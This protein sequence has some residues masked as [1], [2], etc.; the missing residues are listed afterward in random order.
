LKDARAAGA[1]I[2]VW[3][4]TMPS[5]PEPGTIGE[6]IRQWA[7]R[8]PDAP[9]FIAEDRLPLTYGA[10]AELMARFGRT[11][12]DSG[13]GRGDRIGI[14]HSGGAEMASTL[15]SV[16][17][18]ATAVPL[19]ST[20][21][22][23][24]F[25]IHLHD[26]KVTGLIV[27]AGMDTPA[28]AAAEQQGIP[29]LDVEPVDD[30]VAGNIVL[31]PGPEQQARLP[32]AA[33]PDDFVF[34]MATSGT[35]SQ[36]KIVPLRHRHNMRR[37]TASVDFLELREDDRCLILQPL[38]Y[39]GG[40]FNLCA[41]LFSGSSVI[42]L[43]CFD[44]ATFFRYLETLGP[45]WYAGSYTFQYSIH[46]Q[47][48]NFEEAIR[49]S[50]LRFIRTTSGFLDSQ[51]ADGIEQLFGVPVIEAY[52]TTESG[53]I[54][55]NPRPP[56]R[57]KRGTVGLPLLQEVEIMSA[58]GRFLPPTERGEVVV[59]GDQV[60]DGYEN[61]PAA[62]EAAFIDGWYR[63]GDEGFFDEDGYLTLT[64]RI[65]ENINRGGEKITPGEVDDALLRHPDVRE[66][67]TFPIP[68]ATLGEEV[69][70]AVVLEK[71]AAVTDQD[72]NRFLRRRL[73][74]FKVPRRIL[75][76]ASIPKSANGKIQRGQL[77]KAFNLDGVG[78][79]ASV[80]ASEN[81]RQSSPL[82]ARLQELW[83]DSLGLERV[84]LHDNF[85]L[86]GGDSLQAVELF[87]RIEEVLGHR[88]PR[89]S[90]FE[91][92]TVAEM[93][94]GI[95]E[96]APPRCVLPI[97]PK[98]TRPPFFCVHDGNGHVLNFWDLARHLGEEQPFYGIQYVDLDRDQLP[99]TEI[100][101]MAA[102]Y[103][104]EMRKVQPVGPYYIGGYSFGG[105][106]AYVMAQQLRAA[107]QEVALLAL[108]DTFSH[109][110]QRHFSIP[111]R[112]ARHCQRIVKMPLADVPAFAALIIR[113]LAVK[114]YMPLRVKLFSTT[115]RYF[116]S[117][118]RPTPR[119]LSHPNPIAIDV[120]NQDYRAQP[121]D[122]SAVLFKAELY[123][124]SHPDLHDGWHKL[125]KGG[126]E[127]RPVPGLHTSIMKEPHVRTLAAELAECLEERHG[128]P[129]TTAQP[130]P[131]A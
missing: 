16:A 24:E 50:R 112:L 111:Y 106:A 6:T 86:L 82:E 21:T 46:A 64:G 105:R 25:A 101:A 49:R 40:L 61:N 95:E 52:A 84:G 56:G 73:A 89:S 57:N 100:D 51:I 103:I 30:S 31:R 66:A 77:S 1:E 2:T 26:R 12:N 70:A 27:E 65:K 53:R 80:R 107:G 98:G 7:E 41:P 4:K 124:M 115:C 102:H 81:D 68:H 14:V 13:Y 22:V 127:I 59:R 62:N 78:A 122:G 117:R 83:A 69:A 67:T 109:V 35:T 34:V 48:S 43:T 88:L 10:L 90:L 104:R 45:T 116:K 28:R 91:A 118:N 114:A 36:S 97:Q 33:A 39:A 18:Y 75:F 58:E 29:V 37:T 99:F 119:F 128:R 11:L 54:S 76:V 113:N 87:L 55:G 125:I 93:A 15:L 9:A 44:V 60:F 126:L 63:T 131:S 79:P 130:Y 38:V 96:G 47:A 8:T 42:F 74:N 3:G 5:E 123:A 110:G 120:I 20:Y 72:L 129:E 32:G 94:K 92:G 17:S 121:Y 19:L 71:G 85:F 108:F 23:G